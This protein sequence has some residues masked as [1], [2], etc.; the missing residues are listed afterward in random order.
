MDRACNNNIGRGNDAC[1]PGSP[2]LAASGRRRAE[3]IPDQAARLVVVRGADRWLRHWRDCICRAVPCEGMEPVAGRAR[4][5]IEREPVRHSHRLWHLRMGGRP[6]R[7]QGRARGREPAVRD[8]HL[9]G[10]LGRQSQ[11]DGRAAAHC[12]DR[13]RRRHSKRCRAQCRIRPAPSARHACHHRGRLRPDRGRDPGI[14]DRNPGAAL[15]LVDS[16]SD[17][18]RGAG[19][20]CRRSMARHAGIDQIH[21]AAPA[22]APRDGGADRGDQTRFQG[23]SGRTLCDRGRAAISRIQSGLSVPAGAGA[24][25]AAGMAFVCTQSHGLLF[26]PEL[27]TDP[28]DAGQAA[29]G[30]RRPCR[31]GVAGRRDRWIL[32]A[33]LVAAAASFSCHR[34]NVCHRGSRGRRHRI[35]RADLVGGTAD[36]DVLCRLPGAGRPPDSTLSAP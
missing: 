16:V 7:A 20:H 9:C 36:G 33:L 26:P 14:R 19:G 23:A 15:W 34:R 22:R 35:C 11:R 27:D 24:D 30:H 31:R 17:R 25:H 5:G 21:D 3:L 13:D 4:T 1:R 8:L 32:V 2:R 18:R 10:G 29:A 6:L 12:R 28:A